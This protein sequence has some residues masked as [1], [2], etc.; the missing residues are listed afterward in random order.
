[1]PLSVVEQINRVPFKRS[2]E[3]KINYLTFSL[4]TD[5]EN[6][7]KL[8]PKLGPFLQPSDCFSVYNIT[9]RLRL[10]VRESGIRHGT[11]TAQVLHTSATLAVNE[12][13]EPML[14]GDLLKK[15]RAFAPK[16]EQ[17]LHNSA[18]RTVNLCETD[19]HCDLNA[20]AHVKAALF[21]HA[22]VRLIIRDRDSV[23]VEWQKVA[24]IEF[25]GPRKREILVQAMG[26]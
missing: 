16:E 23:F 6:L 11:L 5:Q 9:D 8:D 1:M 10:F 17:Y 22:S 20:D 7:T 4:Q 3:F 13:D 19:T 15:V 24:L 14:L 18:L 21:G 26:Q 12:L 25:D 2:D